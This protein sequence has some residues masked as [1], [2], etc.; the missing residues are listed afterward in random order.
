MYDPDSILDILSETVMIFLQYY[1]L[2]NI[3]VTMTLF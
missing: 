1:C 2:N 3:N